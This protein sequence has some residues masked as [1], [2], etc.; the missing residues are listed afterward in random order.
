VVAYTKVY[1]QAFRGRRANELVSIT[2]TGVFDRAF[3]SRV[4]C[5]GDCIIV[6]KP[7]SSQAT[8]MQMAVCLSS[9]KRP[10]D[11]GCMRR[12]G[13]EVVVQMRSGL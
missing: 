9:T 12:K 10:D 3:N 1:N 8:V 2:F 7:F 5:E 4:R 6:D 13:I 11:R